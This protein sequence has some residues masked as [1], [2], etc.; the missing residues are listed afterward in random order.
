MAKLLHSRG[1]FITFVNTEHNHKRLLRSKGPNYLDGFP[2]FRFET[3]P[4]GLPPSDADI[5]QPTASVCDSTSKN[6]LAPFCNLIS[7]LNDPSSSAGPP[8][9]CIVSDGV[10]SFTLDAAEKFGVPEVLF[11]TTS[12]CGFLG[13]R[14]YRDLLQRGLIPLKGIV[15]L[16]LRLRLHFGSV[17]SNNPIAQVSKMERPV[18]SIGV[19]PVR[20]DQL[21]RSWVG[22]FLNSSRFPKVVQ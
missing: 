18:Q 10:M 3:I 9:T 15:Y 20:L 11:W 13:Y 1:F 16:Y 12:A 2:D 4:D 8:V 22:L 5:S 21:D 17:L 7:K 19:C 6:S 14:H